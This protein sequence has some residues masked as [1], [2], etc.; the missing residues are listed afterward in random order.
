M[1]PRRT[2]RGPLGTGKTGPGPALTAV[3]LGNPAA[4]CELPFNMAFFF[5]F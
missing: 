4:L 5:F 1:K 2:A 3:A